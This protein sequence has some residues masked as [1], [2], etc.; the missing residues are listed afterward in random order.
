[1]V[2][3]LQVSFI[4][5]MLKYNS[6]TTC[7]KLQ[8]TVLPIQELR[9]GSGNESTYGEGQDRQGAS[10][11]KQW[12]QTLMH[13]FL[14]GEGELDDMDCVVIE[15]LLETNKV[16]FGSNTSSLTPF[17]MQML[18][19]VQLGATSRPLT[20]P[21][22]RGLGTLNRFA[23]LAGGP[24]PRHQQLLEFYKK[25]DPDRTGDLEIHV[26]NLLVSTRSQICYRAIQSIVV[27]ELSVFK[28][29]RITEAKIR[30]SAQGVGKGDC[31]RK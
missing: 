24:S 31:G 11:Q 15:E 26:T 16:Y 22:I 2:Y 23:A 10:V 21:A 8:S 12:P 4:A 30:I 27:G 6:I 19:T 5:S 3:Y 17:L 1:M 14:L 25:Y 18:Q 9:G 20:V 7:V 29:C 28:D 13:K